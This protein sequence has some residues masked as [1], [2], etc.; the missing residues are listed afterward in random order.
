MK[1]R[2]LLVIFTL[3][4]IVEGFANAFE[5]LAIQFFSK[6]SLMLILLVYFAANTKGISARKY[7]IILALVSSWLGDIVLLIEKSF[8]A[9]FALGLTAFLIA[10]ASYVSFF[11]NIGKQNLGRRQIKALPMLLVAVYSGLFYLMLFPSLSTLKIPVLIYV[12]VISMMLVACIHAFDFEK[13]DFGWFC[14]AGTLLF[15]ASDSIL[16]FNRFVS[17]IPFGGLFVITLYGIGQLLITE[18]AL[19]NLR[20]H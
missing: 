13:H 4:L 8:G 20:D 11:L 1:F 19:R 3:A 2:S 9:L 6:P 18:G 15:A 14:L 16:A 10:H 17:P 5:I 12:F 7:L